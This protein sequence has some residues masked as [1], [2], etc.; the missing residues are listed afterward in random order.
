MVAVS[1]LLLFLSWPQN[2][3]RREAFS[4]S[5]DDEKA[6]Q[7]LFE[8]AVN[9]RSLSPVYPYSVVPGGVHTLES[10]REAVHRDRVVAQHYSE[11]NLKTIRFIAAPEQSFAFVS[12]RIKD[13]VF[14]TKSRVRIPRGEMLVTDGSKWIRSRCG[15]RISET[16]QTPQSPNEPPVAKL[17]TPEQVSIPPIPLQFDPAAPML[18]LSQLDPPVS[19]PLPLE[20]SSSVPGDLPYLPSVVLPPPLPHR[21]TDAPTTPP[22]DPIPPPVTPVPD[23]ESLLL[24]SSGL[25]VVWSGAKYAKK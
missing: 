21:S 17:D 23:P 12:Y 25:A 1:G 19:V 10:L 20:L 3:V 11:V 22:N 16:P 14:W 4:N 7:R 9:S 15:N 5:R 6:L 13:K 8:A 18:K 2:H 24:L